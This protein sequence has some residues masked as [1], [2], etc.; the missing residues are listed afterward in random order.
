MLKKNQRPPDLPASSYPALISPEMRTILAQRCVK[1]DRT[2][3]AIGDA[4]KVNNHIQSLELC[5][6]AQRQ[7]QYLMGYVLGQM[8]LMS[9]DLE[10]Y[11]LFTAGMLGG[12][13]VAERQPNEDSAG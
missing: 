8:F 1:L 2:L 9:G 13:D 4:L 3:E 11:K 10:G 7:Y 5:I 6:D 12:L